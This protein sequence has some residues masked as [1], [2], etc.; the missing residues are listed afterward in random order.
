MAGRDPYHPPMGPPLDRLSVAPL[1]TGAAP[2]DDDL[3]LSRALGL[4]RTSVTMHKLRATGDLD[5]A[6]A[7][8]AASGLSVGVVWADAALDLRDPATWPVTA[9]GVEQAV[10]VAVVL[11]SPSVL[12]PGGVATGLPFE[13]A[14]AAYTRVVGPLAEASRARGVQLL[15]EPVRTQ[16]AFAGFVHCLRDGL[17]IAE[18]LDLGLMVDVTH[19]WWEP[20]LDGLLHRA[21]PRIRCVHLADLALDRPVLARLVPGDGHLPLAAILASL[22]SAGYT[23]PLELELIGPAIDEEGPPAALARAIAHL[24]GLP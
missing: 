16:F 24:T 23:G 3:A 15:L 5:A 6:V 8:V 17:D 11:G 19:C 13:A 4:G 22:E 18:E 21:A 1:S 7:R 20:D 10:D 12:A 2:L 9:Q 14:R